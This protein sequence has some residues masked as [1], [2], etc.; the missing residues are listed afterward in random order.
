MKHVH[1]SEFGAPSVLV[2]KESP[3]PIIKE[4]EV[5]VEIIA[6]SINRADTL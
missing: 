6:T 5:L 2:L 4:N 3:L 1:I